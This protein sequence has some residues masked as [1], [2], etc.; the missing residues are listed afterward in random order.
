MKVTDSSEIIFFDS[1]PISR[2]EQ[3]LFNV[4][5]TMK[6][7]TNNIVKVGNKYYYAKACSYTT[8]INELIGS[9]YSTLVGLDTVDYLIGKSNTSVSPLYA[10]SE[11]FWKDEYTYT[12]V[13]QCYGMRPD[14]SKV[15]SKG[16][17]RFYINETS[18]LDFVSSPSLVESALKMT[19]VDLKMDQTDRFNYNVVLRRDDG[20]IEMEKLYDYGSSYNE[21]VYNSYNCYINPFLLVKRNVISLWGLA[22]KYPQICESAAKLSQAPLYDVIKNIERR[23]NL[24]IEDKDIPNYLEIDRKN[25]KILRMVR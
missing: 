22:H 25:S 11:V 1:T 8:L 16:F 21:G 15:Y 12:T 2:A 10:L 23:F 6:Y 7:A 20:I 24:K 13:E 4:P 19:A 5:H 14:D 9:Y 17:D 18:I 3:M